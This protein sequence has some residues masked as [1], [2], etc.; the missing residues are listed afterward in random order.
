MRL[1]AMLLAFGGALSSCA[2]PPAPTPVISKPACLP[3]KTY[4]Q[5]EEAAVSLEMRS[6]SVPTAED[7]FIIDYGQLRAENR[8]ACRG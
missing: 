1:L 5:G 3:M 4:T 7:Q 8:A 2:T 6:H